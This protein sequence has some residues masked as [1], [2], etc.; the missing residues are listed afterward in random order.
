MEN[1]VKENMSSEEMLE[2][3]DN[4]GKPT[5]RAKARSLVHLDG[6]AHATSHV[7]LIRA[8]DGSK[9]R[10][11][12]DILLQ[13][14]SHNKDS[15][16]DCYDISS[17]GHIPFGQGYAESAI[18]ELKE[19][20]GLDACENDLEFIGVHDAFNKAEFYGR[21]FLNHEISNVYLLER[22]PEPS[23]FRLQPEEV[24]SVIWMDFDE[25]YDSVKNNLFRH[26]ICMDEMDMLYDALLHRKNALKS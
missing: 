15:F 25:C 8:A 16:P 26:C 10:T 13:K 24:Q 23:E 5:G 3:L 20:L 1:N 7:W 18:R 14:R 12:Y 21:P 17:A 11:G 19:E 2:I 4:T 9:G 22:N 6:D